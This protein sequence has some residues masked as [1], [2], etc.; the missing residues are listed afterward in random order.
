MDRRG[1][2]GMH[3]YSI[4]ADKGNVFSLI[5]GAK[6]HAIV[7]PDANVNA[8]INALVAVGFG[9]AGH[10]AWLAAQLFLLEAQNHGIIFSSVL[11]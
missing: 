1:Q 9:A 7:M 5:W 11:I 10:G 8:I 6:N 3:I 2:A 4:A